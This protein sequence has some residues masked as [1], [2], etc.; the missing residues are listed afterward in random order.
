MER[1]GLPGVW[2]ML[3]SGDEEVKVMEVGRLDGRIGEGGP[4]V[5]FGCI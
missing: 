3:G 5:E 4:V 2:R 1:R